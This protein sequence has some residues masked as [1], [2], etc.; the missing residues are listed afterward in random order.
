MSTDPKNLPAVTA[1]QIALE[2][3]IDAN[4]ERVWQALTEEPHRW[5][6]KDFYVYENARLILEPWP[7]GRLFEDA[8][9]GAGGLWFTIINILPPAMLEFYGHLA[10][11]WGG[12]ATSIVRLSLEERDGKTVLH[13]ADALFGCLR[14]SA[15]QQI[16]EGWQ[17]LF[18][19]G[20]KPYVE[21]KR[22]TFA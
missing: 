22:T 13:I 3:T 21:S 19:D 10:P 15:E 4:R 17:M 12:P 20:L 7:G 6:R 8:G 9:N 1:K 5:W 18:G 14:D 16:S 2:I 11:Q